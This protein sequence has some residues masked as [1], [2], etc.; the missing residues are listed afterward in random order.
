MNLCF[1]PDVCLLSEPGDTLTCY[2]Q[3]I[4]V[5]LIS[6]SAFSVF[7]LNLTSITTY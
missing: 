1:V 2:K 6:K 7:L 3:V 4:F 5:F